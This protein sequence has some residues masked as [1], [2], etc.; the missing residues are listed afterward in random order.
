MNNSLVETLI[1]AVVLLV[2]AVFL[3]F[4]YSSSGIGGSVSGYDLNA[5]FFNAEGLRV[6][7][8]VRLSGVKVGSVTEQSLDAKTYQAVIGMTLRTDVQLPEDSV[9]KISSSGLLG[10]SYVA[11]EPGGSDTMMKPGGTF[12]Y[13]QGSVN[14]MDLISKAIFSS[15]G[16]GSE[17]E[18]AGGAGAAPAGATSK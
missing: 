3:V 5:K 2:A 9:A 8:D 17:G 4:A 6:G 1:G 12:Q 16:S 14:L 7:S 13:T 11:L 10:D 15:V 18:A